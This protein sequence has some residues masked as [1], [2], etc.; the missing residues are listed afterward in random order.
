M[1]KV[2][3]VDGC[4]GAIKGHGFC[5]KHYLRWKNHGTVAD[6]DGSHVSVIDRFWHYADKRGADECWV[7]TGTQTGNGY[8]R[9]AVGGRNGG[10]T[11]AHRFSCELH[12]GPAPFKGA[13]VMHRCDNRGCVNP[14]H[15]AW[16]TSAENIQDAYDKGRK[17]SPFRRGASHHVAK[18]TD[19]KVRFVKSNPEMSAAHL[20]RLLGCSNSSIFAIRSGRTWKHVT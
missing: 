5:N 6:G 20:G 18:L 2:C 13:H 14:A 7:W 1:N 16:C 11:S 4:G 10:V 17:T 12:H 3:S 8:G 19:E 9:I 15:L